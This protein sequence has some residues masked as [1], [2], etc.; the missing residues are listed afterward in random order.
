MSSLKWHELIQVNPISELNL[1]HDKI[2]L[3]TM[4]RGRLMNLNL[5]L[6]A[7]YL[8]RHPAAQI[9]T[10]NSAIS[11]TN[12]MGSWFEKKLTGFK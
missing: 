6:H 4:H 12:I 5:P 9:R 3:P 7:W 2:D 10:P 8:D 11:H 1:E